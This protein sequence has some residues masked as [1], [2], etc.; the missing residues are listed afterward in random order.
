MNKTTI[1]QNRI[2][3]AVNRE[4]NRIEMIERKWR[5]NDIELAETQAHW[6][7]NVLSA[8]KQNLMSE[9]QKDGKW[10]RP[11]R[12]NDWIKAAGRYIHIDVGYGHA[13]ELKIFNAD[14]AIEGTYHRA[15]IS[16]TGE[17]AF[18]RVDCGEEERRGPFCGTY[19][20]ATCI[21]SHRAARSNEITVA[22]GDV[23]SIDCR[24]FR[25]RVYRGEYIALDRIERDGTLT[26]QGAHA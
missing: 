21:T 10:I 24:D 7:E 25:V 1:E 12:D 14:L 11:T 20:L 2:K 17:N 15:A 13:G 9:L 18:A 19:G 8:R 3:A 4:L 6:R 26:P 22:D 23:L 5:V 16:Y